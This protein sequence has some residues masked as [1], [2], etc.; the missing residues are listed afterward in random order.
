MLAGTSASRTPG[1]TDGGRKLPSLLSVTL[2]RGLIAGRAYLAIGIVISLVLTTVLLRTARASTVFVATFP[3]EIPLF[4]TLGALGGMILFVGDRSKGVLEYLISY[5]VR[6]RSLFLNS[7]LTTVVLSTIVMGTALTVGLA[8]YV[9]TGHSISSDLENS[10]LGYTIPMT[11]AAS[12]FAATCGV[13]WSTL[14][15]PRMGLNSPVGVAPLLGVAP[16][17]LVLVVA[18]GVDKSAYYDVTVGAS[19]GFLILVVALLFASSRLMSRERY[20]S[21]M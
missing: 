8:G 15:T 7:L 6:P 3:L 16:P 11:Y 2:R 20:L 13:I 19:L 17:I 9:A 4:A 18:E 21:P 1:S 5:G 14:S 10:I 12:L